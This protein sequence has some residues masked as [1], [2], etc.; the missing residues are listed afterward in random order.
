M[1]TAIQSGEEPER[2]FES[3]PNL[4][5]KWK[6]LVKNG[7]DLQNSAATH[8]GIPR[9]HNDARVVCGLG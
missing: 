2:G 4:K 1:A 8:G 3:R 9:Q 5:R 6:R 7:I